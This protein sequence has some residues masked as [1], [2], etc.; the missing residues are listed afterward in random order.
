[1]GD[2]KGSDNKKLTEEDLD[3]IVFSAAFEINS[4]K[5]L[6]SFGCVVRSDVY[7]SEKSMYHDTNKI[8]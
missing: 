1:M 7:S 2:Y 8:G 6:I 5:I 4:Q 3:K